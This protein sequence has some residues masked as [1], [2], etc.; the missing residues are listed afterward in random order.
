VGGLVFL[1]GHHA[2]DYPWAGLILPCKL[3]MGQQFG[4]G[5]YLLGWDVGNCFLS[6]YHSETM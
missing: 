4:C 3:G 1:G 6:K 5:I 2:P